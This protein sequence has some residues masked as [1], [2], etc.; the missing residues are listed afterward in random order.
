MDKRGHPPVGNTDALTRPFVLSGVSAPQRA[1]ISSGRRAQKY[2]NI[3]VTTLQNM[4]VSAITVICVHPK[5]YATRHLTKSYFLVFS[6][7]GKETI[8]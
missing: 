4:T 6:F 7:T 2:Y 5:L 3:N 8:S 1:K